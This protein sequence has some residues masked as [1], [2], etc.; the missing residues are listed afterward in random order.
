MLNKAEASTPSRQSAFESFQPLPENVDGTRKLST[1]G[2]RNQLTSGAPVAIDMAAPTHTATHTATDTATHIATDITTHAALPT[3]RAAPARRARAQKRKD[4]SRVGYVMT[5][6]KN[7]ASNQNGLGNGL[8]DGLRILTSL[9]A[10]RWEPLAG[11]P[12]V[13]RTEATGGRVFRDPSIV[14]VE[15]VFHLVF[16][17]DLCVGQKPRF[18]KCE[19]L[20]IS[21]RPRARFGYA[22]SRDLLRWES[23][24]LIDVPLYAACSIWAPE[25][26]ALPMTEGGGCMV[27]FSAT[28]VKDG[29]CPPNFKA[30][31]HR[32]WYAL[33]RL[34]VVAWGALIVWCSWGTDVWA[35]R[36]AMRSLASMHLQTTRYA[37]YHDCRLVT[38]YIY[39]GL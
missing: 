32:S 35:M 19:Q 31:P 37:N 12:L 1:E 5:S 14:L 15:G 23:I 36:H 13:L 3:Q 17:S 29:K 21:R 10:R 4:A 18:W 7:G 11:E 22:T 28:Q 25:I 8:G 9:D 38:G 30:T 24:R 33:V 6:F 39:I 26:A 2:L 20:P 34:A 16:T 27:F